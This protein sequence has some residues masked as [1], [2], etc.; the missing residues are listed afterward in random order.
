MSDEK[1]KALRASHTL[2]P[3]P[4]RCAI[5]SLPVG[6]LSLIRV[7][8]CKSNMSFC[9]GCGSMAI[10]SRRRPRC[11]PSLAPPFT[12]PKPPGSR[13]GSMA[14]FLKPTGPR[15]AHKLTEEIM[16]ELQRLPTPCPQ[17]T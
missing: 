1:L 4:E 6:R 12:R 9:D 16:A 15:H 10:P 5:P 11:S 14:C 13:L 3:H 17:Q 8:W 2:H 7:I